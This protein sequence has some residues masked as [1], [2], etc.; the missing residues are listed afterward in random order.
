MTNKYTHVPWCKACQTLAVACDG[1][2]CLFTDTQLLFSEI[3][4]HMTTLTGIKW[5]EQACAVRGELP[6]HTLW[7]PGPGDGTLGARAG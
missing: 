4:M 3:R 1:K 5:G 6:G 2:H 7:L